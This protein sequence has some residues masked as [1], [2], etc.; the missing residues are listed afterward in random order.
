MSLPDIES[1]PALGSQLLRDVARANWHGFDAP[2]AA[3]AQSELADGF[4]APNIP[5]ESVMPPN[6]LGQIG[7]LP[8]VTQVREMFGKLPWW[9]FA[10]AAGLLIFIIGR[11]MR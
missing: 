2:A 5:G 9:S 3:Q 1:L 7:A 4:V 6:L 8:V 10:L 11:K